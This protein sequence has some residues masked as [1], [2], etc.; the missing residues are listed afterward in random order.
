MLGKESKQRSWD[1]ECDALATM[2]A[3][4]LD[5]LC[6]KFFIFLSNQIHLAN[7][8]KLLLLDIPRATFFLCVS[9]LNDFK[10]P[11]NHLSVSIFKFHLK[12]L[13]NKSR[14]NARGIT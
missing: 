6:T 12:I 14:N 9:F 8:L 5:D 2:K 13:F 10:L 1:T 11:C 3:S 7:P 4:L